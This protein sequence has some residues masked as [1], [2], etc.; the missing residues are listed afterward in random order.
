MLMSWFLK[1]PN[2]YSAVAQSQNESFDITQNHKPLNL[3]IQFPLNK[4]LGFN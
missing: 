3:I 4:L 2:Y 1:K